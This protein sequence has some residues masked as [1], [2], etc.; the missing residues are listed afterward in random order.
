[1]MEA[2]TEVLRQS[3]MAKA[4]PTAL[5][6]QSKAY[7]IVNERLRGPEGL[8]NSTIWVITLL[9]HQEYL[10]QRYDIA[11]LHAK[12]VERI[13][14]MRGG[15]EKLEDSRPLVLKL[16]KADIMLSLQTGTKPLYYRDQFPQLCWKLELDGLPLDTF[17]AAASID[18]PMEAGLTGILRDIKSVCVMFNQ[19]KLSY[20]TEVYDFVDMVLSF[21]YRLLRFRGIHEVPEG[22]ADITTMFHSTLLLFVMTTL[23]QTDFR[24]AIKCEAAAKDAETILRSLDM[25]SD[26]DLEV[27]LWAL[28]VGSIWFT[29]D[30]DVQ[31][32]IDR[33]NV[34]KAKLGI[35]SWSD[36]C[37]VLAKFPWL[38][39]LH[40]QPG[41][42][43]WNMTN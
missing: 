42:A 11:E 4:T 34:I 22:E 10:N 30:G 3:G 2:S 16:C 23:L 35:S 28:V 37:D 36:A 40:D 5:S 21:L 8:N 31:W 15:L 9:I 43:T 17:S 32:I 38:A 14:K 24:R 6:Y 33:I 39:S 13:V 20:K 26:A 18:S 7:A 12:G 27:K 25:S 29:A 1:M 19:N 41:E